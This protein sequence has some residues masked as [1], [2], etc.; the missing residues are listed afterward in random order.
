MINNTPRR[1]VAFG[2]GIVL[3][4]LAVVG[5]LL[6]DGH[7]GVQQATRATDSPSVAGGPSVTATATVAP[8]QPPTQTP[9]PAP[10][11]TIAY[12]SVVADPPTDIVPRPIAS[13]KGRLWTPQQRALLIDQDQQEIY[14]YENGRKIKTIP[15][16]SGKPLMDHFTPAWT[17]RVGAYQGTIFSFGVYAD[18]AWYLY[19]ASGDILIHGAPYVYVNG[20]KVYQDLDALGH[21]PSSHGCIRIHPKDADWLTAWNIEGVPVVVL[22][23]QGGFTE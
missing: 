11:P 14:V 21:Y 1:Y 2:A 10:T 5:S 22:P 15:A 4:M 16:S 12:I 3:V 6:L 13:V 9:S 18:D 20:Q 7:G 17:G 8:T 23:W 19:Q